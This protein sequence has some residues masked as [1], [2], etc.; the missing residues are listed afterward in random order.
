MLTACFCRYGVGGISVIPPHDY[1]ERF[2]LMLRSHL[3][4]PLSAFCFFD[5]VVRSTKLLCSWVWVFHLLDSCKSHTSSSE[6]GY[7]DGCG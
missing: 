6:L 1:A 3:N 5:E 4:L 7:G 2:L